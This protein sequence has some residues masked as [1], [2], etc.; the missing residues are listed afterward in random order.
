MAHVISAIQQKG[1][2]GKS[3]LL[4]A[5]ALLL[6]RDGARV[7][8]ID[9]DRQKTC[10]DFH[11]LAD[12]GFDVYP[13]TNEDLLRGV[14]QGLAPKY[15]AILIDTAGIDSQMV[16]YV[17]A[18]S[19]VVL[20][21]S[22]ASRPDAAGAVRTWKKVQQVQE[23]AGKPTHVQVV[24]MNFNPT[25]RITTNVHEAYA[26]AEAPLYRVGLPTLTGFREM[27]TTGALPDGA[28]ARSLAELARALAADNLLGHRDGKA[29]AA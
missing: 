29:R 16:V 17:A 2:V 14:V 6:S 7:V 13:E 8:I 18:S 3:T 5:L 20:I 9:T 24:M 28:A 4:C 10:A 19:D 15:D 22:G 27:H 12:P 21:P 26:A 23:I 25:A 1:G 11:D